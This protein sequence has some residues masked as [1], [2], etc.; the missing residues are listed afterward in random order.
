MT[1][2]SGNRAVYVDHQPAYAA[3]RGT[4]GE[5]P[6]HIP[7]D[8]ELYDNEGKSDPAAE[9]GHPV[10]HVLNVTQ[11]EQTLCS[12]TSLPAGTGAAVPEFSAR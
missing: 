4:A 11:S 8:I 10:H 5:T 2:Q 7:F 3:D 6:Q 12:T 9:R 1:T